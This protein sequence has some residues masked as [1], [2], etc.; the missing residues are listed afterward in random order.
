MSR[1]NGRP[2]DR[3]HWGRPRAEARWRTA[4]RVNEMAR[5]AEAH[6]HDD[7]AAEWAD[8]YDRRYR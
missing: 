5:V 7:L 8:E 2:L 6:R 3:R 1:T 4:A